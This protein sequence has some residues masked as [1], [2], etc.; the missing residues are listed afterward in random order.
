[1]EYEKEAQTQ[2]HKDVYE[3][4]DSQEV[5]PASPAAAEPTTIHQ[6]QPSAQRQQRRQRRRQQQRQQQ[7]DGAGPGGTANPSNRAGP[8]PQAPQEAP[9]SS[10]AGSSTAPEARQGV[11][12]PHE[13]EAD[14]DEGAELSL[15]LSSMGIGA[16]PELLSR[17]EPN[18]A[19]QGQQRGQEEQQWLGSQQR[20]PAPRAPAAPAPSTPEVAQPV[21]MLPSTAQPEHPAPAAHKGTALQPEDDSCVVCMEGPKESVFF[22]CGHQALCQRCTLELFRKCGSSGERECPICRVAVTQYLLQVFRC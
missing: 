20:Q 13:Q 9:H 1:M 18:T 15:M 19:P 4:V 21:S 12:L 10:A 22:P 14:E 2:T 7:P 5:K 3:H 6:Q 16:S 8:G 11:E 17:A